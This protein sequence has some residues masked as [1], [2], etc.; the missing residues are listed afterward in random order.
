MNAGIDL[1][2]LLRSRGLTH[3]RR[4]FSREWCGAAPNYACLRGARQLPDHIV[5]HIIRRL[6]KERR[7]ILAGYV[8]R[9]L[10][11]PETPER[12]SGAK[13]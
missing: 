12:S 11:W 8:M 3:S 5:L 10:L 13:R 6:I 9:Q 4:H 2:H 7:F 1:Y